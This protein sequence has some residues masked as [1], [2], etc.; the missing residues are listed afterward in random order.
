VNFLEM[1]LPI[2]L[3]VGTQQL[4]G[5]TKKLL[6]KINKLPGPLQQLGV[7]GV[8][9]GVTWVSQWVPGINQVLM[10]DPTLAASI[11]AATAF[12]VHRPSR[13]N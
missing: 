12:G 2:V 6:T 8:A 10:A 3:G 5:L 13:L 1:L 4:F 7:V 11:S 9:A